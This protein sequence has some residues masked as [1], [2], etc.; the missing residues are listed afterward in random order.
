MEKNKINNSDKPTPLTSKEAETMWAN[1]N[2]GIKKNESLKKTRRQYGT[3][4]LIVTLLLLTG[5]WGYNWLISPDVYFADGGTLSVVLK[6]GTKV[7]LY[8]N[9]SLTINKSFPGKTRDV[10]LSGD[11]V[12]NVTKSKQHP[13]IVHG[14]NYETKVLGTVF[15]VSQKGEGFTV[16]LY[17]GKV[18][19]NR[20]GTSQANFTLKPNETF[21]NYGHLSVATIE[22]TKPEKS[23]INSNERIKTTTGKM[24]KLSF[25]EC[26]LKQAVNIMEK[27]YQVKVEFPDELAEEKI[28]ISFSQTPVHNIME[29]LAIYLNLK[30]SKYENTYKFE[31]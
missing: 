26:S 3:G 19:I 27:S 13:F 23:G 18:V 24:L 31:K 20:K 10:F 17:E 7:E 9:S 11:A 29:A 12:F 16:D 6:D 30:M 25:N 4:A 22:Q 2:M 14:R 15:K 21:N 1:I 8:K 28:S 5:I